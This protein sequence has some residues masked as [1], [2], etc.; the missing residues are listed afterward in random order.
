MLFS[1]FIF[2]C[3]P[4]SLE[5]V[6]DIPFDATMD[7]ANFTPCNEGEVKQ[8]YVRYSSDVPPGYK[9]EKRA[10]TRE[11]LSAYHPPAS[12]TDNGYVTVRFMVNCVGE[13]GRF[14]ME[15]MDL[16]YKSYN[17]SSD[18]PSQILTI[19]KNLEGWIPRRSEGQEVD[20]YQYLTF[21]IQNGHIIN[22][23]P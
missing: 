4:S 8:Y 13:T 21:K 23:M 18:I 17:F 11:I 20:Y 15:T 5:N 12:S 19:V 2:S 1:L 9:G 6:G 10:M 22:I 7:D 3:K 14:R 16:N